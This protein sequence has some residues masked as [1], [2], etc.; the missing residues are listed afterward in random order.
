MPKKAF[1]GQDVGRDEF[2]LV[3]YACVHREVE[4]GERGIAQ[5]VGEGGGAPFLCFR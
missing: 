5:E 1:N 3:R 4:S 2:Q